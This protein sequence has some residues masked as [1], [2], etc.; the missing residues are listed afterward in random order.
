MGPLL[1]LALP[2]AGAHLLNLLTLT[3]DRL[4]IGQFVGTNSLAALGMAHAVAMIASTMMMGMAVGMLAGVARNVGQGNARLAGRFFGQGILVQGALGLLMLV[5][6][7]FLPSPILRFMGA[8]AAVF[9]PAHDYL[10]VLLGGGLFNGLLFGLMFA[11]QG[12]GEA[13]ATLRLGVIAPIINVILDPIFIIVLG[14]GLPGAAWATV[15]SM[16]VAVLVGW[17][18][19]GV[20]DLRFEV[21]ADA[22]RPNPDVLKR[23]ISVGVPGT[24]EHVVRNVAAFSLVFLLTPFGPIILSAYT[25]SMVI[26]M[27]FIFPGIAVGQATAAL[28]GQNLG[29]KAPQRA[30]QTALV[31]T[32]IY[33]AFMVVVGLFVYVFAG[34]LVGVFDPNPAVVAEGT[35]L[36]RR[37]VLCFPFIAIALV[38]SKAFGGAG[39]TWPAMAAAALAH[40]A[41]QIPLVIV[42]SRAYGPD[43]AYWGMAVAF[44][45]HGVLGASFFL[46][47]FGHWRH[48][49]VTLSN[50]AELE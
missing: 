44:M 32:G 47:A 39:R 35:R 16:A 13:R 26:L 49:S 45:V 23:I 41:V 31:S 9:G 3:I 40:L 21:F 33:T 10:Q 48:A 27:M 2:F 11:L 19:M 17:R 24:L 38:L 15:I 50:A 18:M 28:V 43:G 37:I 36:V 6:A 8:D 30:Y 1:R 22:F 34:P 20:L 12:A 25:T 29:A 5:A 4:W 14:L 42:L 7:F 46:Y